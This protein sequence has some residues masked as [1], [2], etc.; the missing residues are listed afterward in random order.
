MG[1]VPQDQS[2]TVRLAGLNVAHFTDKGGLDMLVPLKGAV[3]RMGIGQPK[4]RD[5]GE[6]GPSVKGGVHIQLDGLE[7]ELFLGRD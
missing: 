6:G 4:Q 5:D 2:N 3:L 1:I 7:S